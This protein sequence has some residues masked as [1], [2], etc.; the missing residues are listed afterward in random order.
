MTKADL[1]DEVSVAGKIPRNESEII[2]EAI[3]ARIARSVI[4][5]KKIEIRG[6]AADMLFRCF[7]TTGGQRDAIFRMMQI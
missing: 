2:V 3:F 6:S 1:I 7:N 4:S 5:G